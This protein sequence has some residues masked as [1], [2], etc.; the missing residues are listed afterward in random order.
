MSD[1]NKV[2]F[3]WCPPEAG[4]SELFKNILITSKR[5]VCVVLIATATIQK[6][7]IKSKSVL[8]IKHSLL[9][10]S[11]KC[12]LEFMLYNMRVFFADCTYTQTNTTTTR[13]TIRPRKVSQT[14]SNARV[15][16]NNRLGSIP[17]PQPLRW[18]KYG[19]AQ[20]TTTAQKYTPPKMKFWTHK[21][22]GKLLFTI[23][24]E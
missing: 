24:D 8:V 9:H 15:V 4:S 5:V 18:M 16:F 3:L 21:S 10:F 17:K 14:T 2:D 11:S 12:R 7:S 1:K 20:P 19:T 13:T 6:H 23:F 22:N